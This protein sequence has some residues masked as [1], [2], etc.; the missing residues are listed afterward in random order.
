MPVLL[1]R[2]VCELLVLVG[3]GLNAAQAEVATRFPDTAEQGAMVIGRVAPDSSVRYAGRDLRVTDYGTVVFGIARDAR[4]PAEVTITYPDGRVAH[5]QIAIRTHD[6]PV[7]RVNGV[8]Q[9]T[10]TPPPA[11][12]KR[13]VREQAEVAAVRRSSSDALGSVEVSYEPAL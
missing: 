8:P 9:K 6:W 7:Q 2:R 4:Q 12:A 13:I 1:L 3:L 11:V 5:V 10:A